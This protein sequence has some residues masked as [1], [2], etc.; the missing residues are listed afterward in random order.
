[1]L[2]GRVVLVCGFLP[3]SYARMVMAQGLATALDASKQAGYLPACEDC[4]ASEEHYD[5]FE[6]LVSGRDYHNPALSPSGIAR[7]LFPAQ[8]RD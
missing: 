5:F 7:R 6:S 1:M 8:A 4:A 2:P 3:R